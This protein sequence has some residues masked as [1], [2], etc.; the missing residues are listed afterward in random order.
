M[1]FV[2][3]F[4]FLVFFF[5]MIRRPPRSTRTDTLFPYT[6]LFR[7]QRDLYRSLLG[8]ASH[9]QDAIVTGDVERLTALVDR[10]EELL[11]HLRALETERMTALE[12][13]RAHV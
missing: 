3:L 12:I 6:A 8:V 5:L 4:V 11:D 9:E 13:G 2:T 7:S 10:K 1:V